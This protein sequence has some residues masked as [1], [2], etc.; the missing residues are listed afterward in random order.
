MTKPC[1]QLKELVNLSSFGYFQLFAIKNCEI[2]PWLA[3]V[4][5]FGAFEKETVLDN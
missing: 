1:K 3:K 2:A 4:V 5:N